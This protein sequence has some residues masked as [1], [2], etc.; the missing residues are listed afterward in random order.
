MRMIDRLI[1]AELAH[2]QVNPENRR[3]TILQLTPAGHRIVEE[4]TTRRRDEI[5]TIVE[6]MPSAQRNTLVNA[7]NSFADAADE[8]AVAHARHDPYPLGWADPPSPAA[9]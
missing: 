5:A 3:E 2:R 1:T 7:L 6:R 9:P 8:P 4:V